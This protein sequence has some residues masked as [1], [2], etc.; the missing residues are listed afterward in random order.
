MDMTVYLNLVVRVLGTWSLFS[1]INYTKSLSKD[2][3]AK[4][5]YL[6]IATNLSILVYIVL[7]LQF[8]IIEK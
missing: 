2:L 8:K 5:R 1:L 7:I 3:K 4:V 6:K